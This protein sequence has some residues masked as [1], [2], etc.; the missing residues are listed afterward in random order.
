MDRGHENGRRDVRVFS[1]LH[2]NRVAGW[3]PGAPGRLFTPFTLIDTNLWLPFLLMLIF[4]SFIFI[5]TFKNARLLSFY[6]LFYLLFF[7]D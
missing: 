5:K 1:G 2:S 6:S 3:S 7:N 4:F